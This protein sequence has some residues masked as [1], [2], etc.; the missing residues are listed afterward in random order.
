MVI[1]KILV[2]FSLAAPLVKRAPPYTT[3]LPTLGDGKHVTWC[4]PL[5]DY[6]NACCHRSITMIILQMLGLSSV[7]HR[8]NPQCVTNLALG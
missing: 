8:L 2:S 3:E 1:W 6:L 5:S 7:A 4:A